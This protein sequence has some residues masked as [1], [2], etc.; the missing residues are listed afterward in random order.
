MRSAN[1]QKAVRAYRGQIP[2]SP[3]RPTVA[4]REDRVKFW[5]AIARDV[6]T[7]DAAVEAGVSSPFA[8]RWFRQ[9][10][11]CEPLFAVSGVGPIVKAPHRR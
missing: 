3:G 8:F 10:W 6:K 5:A 9:R 4:W 1:K 7:E 11:W 2:A